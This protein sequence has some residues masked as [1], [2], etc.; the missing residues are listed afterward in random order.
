[1]A[2]LMVEAVPTLYPS[3]CRFETE[4]KGGTDEKKELE[5]NC[6]GFLTF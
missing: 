5:H 3:S 6:L 4:P 2:L 1:M